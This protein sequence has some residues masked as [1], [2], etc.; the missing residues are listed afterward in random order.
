MSS[1]D[2]NCEK[3]TTRCPPAL[4]LA[5]RRSRTESLP[6]ASTSA[7]SVVPGSGSAPSKRYGWL[8]HLRSCIIKDWSFFQSAV[9]AAAPSPSARFSRAPS[10][11]DWRRR[12]RLYHHRWQSARGHRIFVSIFGGSFFS[13]SRLTR[14]SIRHPMSACA[15]ASAPPAPSAA[16]AFLSNAAS[17][18]A[19]SGNRSGKRKFRSAQSSWRS[20]CRGVP[21]RRRACS[22]WSLRTLLLTSD[23]S[24]LMMWPSSRTTYRHHIVDASV[25]CMPGDLAISNVVTTRSYESTSRS[26]DFRRSRSAASAEWSLTAR[27]SGVNLDD[28]TSQLD[29]TESG[30]MT[31]KG[32]LTFRSTRRY[33]R[34]LRVCKVFPRPISS[35]R[36]ADTP[37]S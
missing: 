37:S 15:D 26:L 4:S 3:R 10:K 8:Q 32:P 24:F 18:A 2:V 31:R 30:Q 28:S 23:P 29:N 19:D 16:P 9:A 1:V 34:K 14:R 21:V 13:T 7:S 12:S 11:C 20:F 6:L 36:M 5:R 33:R 35:A 25:D 22:K 17:N 27:S